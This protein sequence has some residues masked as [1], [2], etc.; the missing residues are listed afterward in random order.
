[1][2]YLT[3]LSTLLSLFA[4]SFL[5]YGQLKEVPLVERMTIAHTIIEGKVISQQSFWDDNHH[6][7]YTA[8]KIKIYKIFKGNTLMEELEIITV[9]GV[10]G[11]DKESVSPSLQFEIGQIGIFLLKDNNVAVSNTLFRT[12][13]QMMPAAGP[14]GF[15]RYDLKE[16]TAHEPFHEYTTITTRLYNTITGYT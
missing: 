10:V 13:Y 7:I 1:M 5:S 14:Q 15:V 9:G 16:G 8:N 4:F 11:M 2:K 3:L 6:N 12:T